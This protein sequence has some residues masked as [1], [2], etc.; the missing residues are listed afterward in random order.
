MYRFLLRPKWLAFHV[1]CISLI[2]VMLL[3]AKWQWTRYN[4]RNDFVALVEQRQAAKPQDL[5]TLLET[6]P[7]AE[8][9]YYRVTA[10]GSYLADDQLIQINRTQDDVNGV[11][12][13]TP[14][15]IDDGPIVI[16][17]RG[18]VP[19][20]DDVPA[21]PSGTSLIGGTARTTQI[22]HTGELTD[23]KNGVATEVRRVDLP[24]IGQRLGLDV[25]PVYIDFI[26]SEPAASEPPVPVPPPDVSG[27]P[28]HLSYTIQWC[29]F[30]VCVA[31]G[32]VLAVRRSARK[33]SRPTTPDAAPAV[34]ADEH[35]AV[36]SA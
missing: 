17:N 24:L 11:D 15:Q 36:P 32:W 33:Y 3:L 2:A 18:F 22:R 28:P 9:E 6:D 12:V 31:V 27:G 14:F 5:A 13:L 4:E 35:P 34:S 29:I 16:V 7:P 1:L 8:I 20:G 21:A 26:A 23:N 25:A 10:S 30:S 19:A